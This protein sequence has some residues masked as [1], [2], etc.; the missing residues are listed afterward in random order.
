MKRADQGFTLVEVVVALFIFALL[1]AAGVS[2]LSFAVRAQAAS[3]RALQDV[4][5]ERRLSALLIADLGEAVP[6]ISRDEAGRVRPAFVANQGNTLVGFVRG[7]ASPQ[8]VEIRL[9]KGDLVRVAAPFV[10]GAPSGKPMVLETGVES[11]KLRFRTKG[12]WQDG[13]D[14]ERSDRL[15]RALE[16]TIARQ[17]QAPVT[18][19]FLVGAGT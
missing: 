13:W 4:S 12:D 15:P 8:H 19:M 9:D 7:G 6:R 14:T 1:A 5:G 2:L 3:A 17:G 16:M 18:R 10:D 11:V